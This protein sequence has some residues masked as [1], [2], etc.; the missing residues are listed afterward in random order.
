MF[1]LT[2]SP[3]ENLDPDQVHAALKKREI[4][5]VDVREPHEHQAERIAGAVNLPLSRFD[6]KAL[7]PDGRMAVLHCAGGVRSAQALDRCR[8]AGV[9]VRRHL[10]GGINA[11]KA[12][13]LPTQR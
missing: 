2:D 6:A 1:S 12:A 4:V 7:S 10:K 9:D 5:L 3:T 11:W 13:G 8:R